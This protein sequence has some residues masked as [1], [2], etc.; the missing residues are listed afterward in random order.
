[1]SACLD[2]KTL[3]GRFYI[4]LALLVSKATFAKVHYHLT[5]RL[6]LVGHGG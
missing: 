1:M 6:L 3:D 4:W 2:L 5:H